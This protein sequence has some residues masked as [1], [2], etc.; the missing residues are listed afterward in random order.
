MELN[1]N[2]SRAMWVESILNPYDTFW[3]LD[4]FVSRFSDIWVN[5][6]IRD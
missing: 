1:Q 4:L 6:V 2:M 5:S 3:T